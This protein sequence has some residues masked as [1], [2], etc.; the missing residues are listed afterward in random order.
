[1]T[2]TLGHGPLSGRPALGN[3]EIDGPKHRLYFQD[4]PRR[5]RGELGGEVIV[6]ST[7]AKLLH[8]TGLLPQLYVP[9]EDLRADALE[10]SDHATHCPFKGDAT[11][12]SARA[13]GR[14]A[15]DA[16]WLYEQPLPEAQWLAGHAGCYLDRLDRWLDEEDEVLHHLRDPYHRVDV[17]RTTRHV[18]VLAGDAVVAES[19]RALLLSE[20]GI[21][22]RF[23]L[24][25]ED[26]RAPLA[27]PTERASVC[28]YKGHATWWDVELA[29][30]RRLAD[31]AWSY[32]EPTGDAD[33]VAGHVSF[34]GDELSV[35]VDGEPVP[36]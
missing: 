35:V 30:G 13:G 8:E 26:V 15:Q 28:P 32:D 9:V 36:A 31:A 14:V 25:R 3:Y 6:D 10:P 33:A 7:R 29:D 1:M 2:L 23:Y 34:S 17:R 18:R 20:T 24:P 19:T 27:G 16:F 22:N 11:Y 12:R 5:I 21:P 4:F